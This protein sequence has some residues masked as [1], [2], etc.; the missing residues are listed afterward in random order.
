MKTPLTTIVC[1]AL[2]GLLALSSLASAQQKTIKAC[3]DEWR[4]NRAEN[5]AKGITEQAYVAQCRAGGTTAQPTAPTAPG[6]AK[7]TTPTA[8]TNAPAPKQ[9]PAPT[10]TEANQFGT[11]ALAKAHCPGDIVVWANLSTRVYHFAG[12]KVYGKTKRGAYMCEKDSVAASFRAA[13]N[14]KRPS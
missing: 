4:A 12:N 3:Q 13:K 2:I 11:E 7:S 9:I 5:Q 1:S 8:K 6:A 10:A 14:E